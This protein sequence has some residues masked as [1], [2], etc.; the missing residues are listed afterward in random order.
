[1]QAVALMASQG[2]S[3]KAAAGESSLLLNRHVAVSP[4]GLHNRGAALE[5]KLQCSPPMHFFA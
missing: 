2:H 3:A 4:T 1:M 5:E